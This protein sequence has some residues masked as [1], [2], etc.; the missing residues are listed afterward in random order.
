MPASVIEKLLRAAGDDVLVGAQALAVWMQAYG[1]PLPTESPAVTNDIDF[2]TSS[3]ANWDSVHKFAAALAGQ[4]HFPNRRAMTALV[5]QA[6]RLLPGDQYLNVDVI[7]SLTGLTT[8]AVLAL[9]SPGYAERFAPPAAE[10]AT[11]A[12]PRAKKR[13]STRR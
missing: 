2:L 5:G 4:T 13:A 3:P 9:M 6:Y 11:A 12:P 8:P 10:P 7:W 1:V